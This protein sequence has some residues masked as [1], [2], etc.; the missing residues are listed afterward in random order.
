MR[1][2]TGNSGGFTL[3]ELMLAIAILLAISGAAVSFLMG[4]Q[5]YYTSTALKADLHSGMRGATE[6]LQ[7]EIS[8]A[9]LLTLGP[10][11]SSTVVTGC[12]T[13]TAN[14][15]GSTTAQTVAV[16]STAGMFLAQ[17]GSPQVGEWLRIDTG[18]VQ[19]TVT[20]TAIPS[21]TTFTAVFANNHSSGAVV[22]AVGMFPQGIVDAVSSGSQL[23]MFGDM[24][25]DGN[26][27]FVQYQCNV[28]SSGQLTRSITPLTA[29]AKNTAVI[30]L[31]NLLSTGNPD[32][33]PCFNYPSTTQ[34][35]VNGTTYTFEA[36]V[37][38]TLTLQTEEIDPLIQKLGQ[39]TNT[40]LNLAPRNIVAGV[41]L[42]NAG[43]AN[44]L[45]PNPNSCLIAGTC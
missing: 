30:L 39:E 19:E 8:Q 40:F 3:L 5:N 6:L 43:N 7:Q 2:E 13:L 24:N 38:V 42:A 22:Q 18:A 34:V 21:S 29:T 15:T 35:I 41:A 28:A 26:L 12:P 17:T 31:D 25:G 11:C 36:A 27:Y 10:N 4:F 14:V 45:Q 1:K 33:S 9:G 32:G 20:V 23:S 44:Y 16:S 37:G